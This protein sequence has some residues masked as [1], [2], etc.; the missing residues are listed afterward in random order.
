M[1][2]HASLSLY[3]YT[4]T[5][6]YLLLYH[7]YTNIYIDICIYTYTHTHTRI[8]MDLQ[9][10]HLC[11]PNAGWRGPG[12]GRGLRAWTTLH[13]LY[14][15][16]M[17]GLWQF[18]IGLVRID[19][20]KDMKSFLDLRPWA[21]SGVLEPWSSS[22]TSAGRS[23]CKVNGPVGGWPAEVLRPRSSKRSGLLQSEPLWL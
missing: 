4:Y 21:S 16:K 11:S 5:Y 13:G 20:W 19:E 9:S 17:V 10:Q 18:C 1:C 7:I 6:Q 23:L 2:M 22:C 3:I 15:R 8:W 12:R 14:P